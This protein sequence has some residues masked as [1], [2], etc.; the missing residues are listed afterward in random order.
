MAVGLQDDE[1]ALRSAI[2]AAA[3]QMSASGLS[4]GRSGNV[5]CRYGDG[6]LI[7]PSAM[8]YDDMTPR[9]VV[10]IDREGIATDPSQ[11]PSSEWRFHIAAFDAQTE[12]RALVHTH[13]LH[14][15]ALACTRRPIPAFHYMVAVAGG[16]EIPL[17]P[18]ALFGSEALAEAVGEGLARHR[19]CLLANHGVVAVGK[20]PD[21]ALALAQDVETLAHQ[22][23][24][25]C[26]FDA[27]VILSDVEM[28]RV[29][30]RFATYGKPSTN[31]QTRN[32]D[33]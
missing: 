10:Q 29:H 17:A 16:N 7:T 5:S 22:Y 20:T 11:T 21:E 24:I 15:T 31:R 30:R 14:A 1:T 4:P 27:P 23:A 3:Q 6:I 32:G 2:V 26:Q 28:R 8:P 12:A 9:D 25:A 33:A 19:A 13:S 18:Y